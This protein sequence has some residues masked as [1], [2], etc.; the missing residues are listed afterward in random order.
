MQSNDMAGNIL[1]YI[2]TYLSF[3]FIWSKWQIGNMGNESVVCECC[4]ECSASQW[5]EYSDSELELDNIFGSFFFCIICVD[6]ST[7]RDDVTITNNE[8]LGVRD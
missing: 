6:A 2:F 3:F 7:W 4:D 1:L 5:T 8:A